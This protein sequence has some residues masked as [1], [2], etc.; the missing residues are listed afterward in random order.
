MK[1][2]V[3]NIRKWVE[4]L[5]SGKY[6]QCKGRMFDPSKTEYCCLG[7][8]CQLHAD[9][10]RGEFDDN[11]GYLR[12]SQYLPWKVMEWLGV[13]SCNPGLVCKDI[14]AKTVPATHIND[15]L[16]HSFKDIA[17]AIEETYLQDAGV[18]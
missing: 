10:N 9:E 15:K 5:N 1:P 17:E 3:E 2:N 8:A 14:V 7:V 13:D 11:G 6:K 18:P 4:A 16:E 12:C